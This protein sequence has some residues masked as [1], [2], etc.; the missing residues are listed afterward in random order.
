MGETAEEAKEAFETILEV[1]DSTEQLARE[2]ARE[3]VEAKAKAE[4]IR[5]EGI[6]AAEAATAAAKEREAEKEAEFRIVQSGR[7]DESL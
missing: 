4:R 1:A 3:Q 5:T 7:H 2:A 6:E